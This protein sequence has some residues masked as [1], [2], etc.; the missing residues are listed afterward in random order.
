MSTIISQLYTS[1]NILLKLLKKRGFSTEDYEGFSFNEIRTL[2][3]NNQLDMLLTTKEGKKVY[4]KYHVMTK[5][6]LSYVY[7]WV[8]DL[9][10]LE[11]VLTPKD[12]LIVI[13][14]DK[15]NDSLTKMM[16]D[17]FIKDKIFIIIFNLKQLQFN[18]LEHSLV[19]PHRILSKPEENEIIKKYNIRE[20]KQFPEISRFDPVAKALGMRPDSVCE[21]IRPNKSAIESKYYRLCY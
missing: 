2:Y 11:E 15:I 14:K 10:N 19:S 1:R 6:R 7:D 17:I 18:I 21:I 13:T 5:L 20:R 8:E 3:N 12:E 16:G 4:V 9:Y